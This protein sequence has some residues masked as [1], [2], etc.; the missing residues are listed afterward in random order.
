[1]SGVAS[2]VAEHANSIVRGSALDDFRRELGR[3]LCVAFDQRKDQEDDDLRLTVLRDLWELWEVDFD[4]GTPDM[5]LSTFCR[6]TISVTESL[7]LSRWALQKLDALEASNAPGNAAIRFGRWMLPCLEDSLSDDTICEICTRTRN[8]V[9]LAIQHLLHERVAEATDV[10]RICDSRETLEVLQKFTRFGHLEHLVDEGF[11]ADPEESNV[12]PFD[13]RFVA[14][15]L[16]SEGYLEVAIPWVEAA[17][18]DFSWMGSVH[19]FREAAEQGDVFGDRLERIIIDHLEAD[20][21][22]L[23]IGFRLYFAEV[24]KAFYVWDETE[25]NDEDYIGRYNP[26]YTYGPEL[27]DRAIEQGFSEIALSIA[28]TIADRR[29]AKRGR[30]NYRKACNYLARAADLIDS[31]D[32][33]IRWS[34]LIAEYADRLDKLPAFRDEADK[35]GLLH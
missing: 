15:I 28:T 35:A 23:V 31:G 26:F 3:E 7:Q 33:P 14:E 20:D 2:A 12:V 32:V 11:L 24:E 16:L 13:R 25:W 4:R 9:R 6:S 29:I 21:P 22:G 1:M 8:P 34:Q 30:H 5:E 19:A 17:L 10:A 18:D 27:L